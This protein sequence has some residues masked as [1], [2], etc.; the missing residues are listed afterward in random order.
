MIRYILLC[1]D[2]LVHLLEVRSAET[3][4]LFTAVTSFLSLLLM[5]EAKHVARDDQRCNDP[6]SLAFLLDVSK[7]RSNCCVFLL[8][9]V[10]DLCVFVLSPLRTSGY[11]I[12]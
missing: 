9:V 12:S 1:E 7:T 10:L 11:L 2:G 8:S 3:Q 4:D 5:E 6:S